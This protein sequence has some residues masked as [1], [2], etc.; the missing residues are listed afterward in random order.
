MRISPYGKK[1]GQDAWRR[2]WNYSSRNLPRP[3]KQL[4]WSMRWLTLRLKLMNVISAGKTKLPSE[5]ECPRLSVESVRQSRARREVKI[6]NDQMSVDCSGALEC[7]GHA[8]AVMLHLGN[9]LLSS[10][11]KFR[12]TIECNPETGRFTLKREVLD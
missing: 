1:S 5:A 8:A 10:Q 7:M 2:R 9:L 4:G 3:L 11:G 12:V 6:M